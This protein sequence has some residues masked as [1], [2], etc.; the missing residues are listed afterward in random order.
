MSSVC[1]SSSF[2]VPC[3]TGDRMLFTVPSTTVGK[4][5]MH[6]PTANGR[7]MGNMSIAS[8]L[9]SDCHTRQAT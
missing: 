1:V 2:A 8:A 6:R 9:A 7:S 3:T 5:M 4:N